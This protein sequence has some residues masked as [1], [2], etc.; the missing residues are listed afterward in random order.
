M[1]KTEILDQLLLGMDPYESYGVPDKVWLVAL[2][3]CTDV[4]G[5]PGVDLLLSGHKLSKHPVDA[6]TTLTYHSFQLWRDGGNT[7]ILPEHLVAELKA[8]RPQRITQAKAN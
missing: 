4:Y 3:L 6:N 7:E 8:L 1:S 2:K 5:Q